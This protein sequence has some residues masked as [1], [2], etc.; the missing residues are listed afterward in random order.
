MVGGDDGHSLDPVFAPRL[1]LRHLGIRPIAARHAQIG[2]GSGGFFRVRRKRTR[3]QFILI[4][5]TRRDAVHSANK[6]PP[7]AADHAKADS[8]GAGHVGSGDG[9]GNSPLG[10][11]GKRCDHVLRRFPFHTCL[12]IP[13]GPGGLAP[14]LGPVKGV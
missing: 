6:S 2:G 5:Q 9:H 7:S 13:G 8:R 14:R 1:F 4:I 10:F 3:D 11:G 12:N